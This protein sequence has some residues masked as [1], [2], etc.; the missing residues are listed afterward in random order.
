[1]SKTL[2]ISPKNIQAIVR[3]EVV[4]VMR[5]VLSD[6]DAG[7]EITPSFSR[8]LKKSLKDEKAGRVIPLSK[9]FKQYGI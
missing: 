3:E 7:L 2:T 8:R 6:P 1:M 4:G 5:E 9:I